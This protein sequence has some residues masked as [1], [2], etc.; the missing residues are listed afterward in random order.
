MAACEQQ[1]EYDDGAEEEQVGFAHRNI[2]EL[3]VIM[4]LYTP[5]PRLSLLPGTFGLKL[6]RRPDNAQ[7]FGVAA[8]DVKKCREGGITTVEGVMNM[9]IREFTAVKG[10]SE[11][12]VHKLQE[13]GTH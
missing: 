7:A 11:D 8:A 10:M 1:Q 5:P 2:D 6:T 9:P 3:L 4:L 12:K 13:A